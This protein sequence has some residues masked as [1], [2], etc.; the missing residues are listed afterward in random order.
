MIVP[1]LP[2]KN[3]YGLNS[4]YLN[5]SAAQYATLSHIHRF[6]DNGELKTRLR[7]G[8]YERDLWASVTRFGAGTTIDNINSSTVGHPLS[9]GPCGGE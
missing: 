3:Y 5:S 4:D 9:Q 8:R 6:D 7:H 1:S 2:A